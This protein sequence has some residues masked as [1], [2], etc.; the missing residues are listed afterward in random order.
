MEI[1]FVTGAML[2]GGSAVLVAAE[3]KLR[4]R[5]RARRGEHRD[6]PW[7]IEEADEE[8]LDKRVD[9]T[10]DHMAESQ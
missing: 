6:L 4:R 1:L 2:A 5:H 7:E 10:A 9:R 8:S 3:L